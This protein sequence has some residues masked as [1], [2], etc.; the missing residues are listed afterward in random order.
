[1]WSSRGLVVKLSFL[2]SIQETHDLHTSPLRTCLAA[3]RVWGGVNR[4]CQF[5]CTVTPAKRSFEARLLEAEAD[6]VMALFLRSGW[7]THAPARSQ[8]MM[9]LVDHEHRSSETSR[10]LATVRIKSIACTQHE[11]TSKYNSVR[12]KLINPPDALAAIVKRAG[13]STLIQRVSN[14]SIVIHFCSD[15]LLAS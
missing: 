5:V 8:R 3:T 4:R 15:P 7:A 1:M 11:V 9:M 13:V 2:S 6:R 14:A 12:R 10:S